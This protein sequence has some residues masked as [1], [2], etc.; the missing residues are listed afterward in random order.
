MQR[1]IFNIFFLYPYQSLSLVLFQ[2]NMRDVI[3]ANGS[4]SA[5]QI[6][7]YAFLFMLH[8]AGSRKVLWPLQKTCQKP[9]GQRRIW[10]FRAGDQGSV[11]QQNICIWLGCLSLEWT[12]LVN[13]RSS[14][15]M[16]PF[17]RELK[18][19]IPLY[20]SENEDARYPRQNKGF[21]DSST[22]FGHTLGVC[23]MAQCA[24]LLFYSTSPHGTE[25]N[26]SLQN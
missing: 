7:F 6:P 3:G 25:I 16:F 23:Q 24:V 12:Q 22:V 4:L 17:S 1:F 8:F 2:Q 18:D 19:H 9:T 20:R 5:A 11:C 26:M 13:L 14:E 10:R 15:H 21:C